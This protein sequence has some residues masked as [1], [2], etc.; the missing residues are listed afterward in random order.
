M[1]L[2]LL[3]GGDRSSPAIGTRAEIL[4]WL[5]RLLP[6]SIPRVHN[7]TIDWKDGK[8]LCAIVDAISPGTIPDADKLDPSQA[9]RNVTRGVDSALT[10]LGIP[11]LITPQ[12]MVNAMIPEDQMLKYLSYF[13]ALHQ[14]QQEQ[15]RAQAEKDGTAPPGRPSSGGRRKPS[16]S[17]PPPAS[18]SPPPSQSSSSSSS[19]STSGPAASAAKTAGAAAAAAPAVTQAKTTEG[20]LRQG[21]SRQLE[22]VVATKRAATMVALSRVEEIWRE[23]EEQLASLLARTEKA[24]RERDAAVSKLTAAETRLATCDARVAR[25]EE[26]VREYEERAEESAKSCGRAHGEAATAA[27]RVDGLQKEEEE[28]RRSITALEAENEELRGTVSKLQWQLQEKDV[29]LAAFKDQQQPGS[30]EASSG[31]SAPPAIEEATM[32][33]P[34]QL[35][36]SPGTPQDQRK[37]PRYAVQQ[38]QQPPPRASSSGALQVSPCTPPQHASRPASPSPGRPE[39]TNLTGRLIKAQKR[40][41]VEGQVFIRVV[42]DCAT[43]KACFEMEPAASGAIAHRLVDNGGLVG[44]G[45]DQTF[46]SN[47]CSAIEVSIRGTRDELSCQVYWLSALWCLSSSLHKKLHPSTPLP[48]SAPVAPEPQMRRASISAPID[49]SPSQA[50]EMF[51][52]RSLFD[53]Y[54]TVLNLEYREIDAVLLRSLLDNPQPPAQSKN[55]VRVL[56][57]LHEFLEGTRCP[58]QLQ[59]LIWE[60]TLYYINATA[61]NALATRVD[62]CTSSNGIQIKMALGFLDDWIAR[63][64]QVARSKGRLEHLREAANVLLM[65]RETLKDETLLRGVFSVLSRPQIDQVAS[66]MRTAESLRGKPKPPDVKKCPVAL[67]PNPAVLP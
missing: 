40:I 66:N 8:V 53:T 62:L 38:S 29:A 56:S 41:E 39:S 22:A 17:S 20:S 64:P 36:V 25:A 12:Q 13:R 2:R 54:M 9:I 18:L 48:E 26:R 5:S 31:S 52:R 50:L 44:E 49:V 7:L 32:T 10:A 28:L 23:R 3:R 15:A 35:T 19:S 33:S 24:E 63:H 6:A 21:Q 61:F 51:V 55:V 46:T 42:A 45:Q 60:R 4:Q 34:P 43:G 11:K 16:G 27:A 57:E 30:E 58:T 65:H 14:Q 37:E 67:E 1:M 47:L 59:H